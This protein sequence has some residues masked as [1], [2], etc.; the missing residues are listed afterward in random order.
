MP[1]IAIGE[2][3]GRSVRFGDKLIHIRR[4]AQL[5]RLLQGIGIRQQLRFVTRLAD[6][7]HA[8]G[9]AVGTLAQRHGDGRI[10]RRGVLR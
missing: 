4:H 3:A 8:D 10:V 5:G 1:G 7:G 6:E 2:G 9:H